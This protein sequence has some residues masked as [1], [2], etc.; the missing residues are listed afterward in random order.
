VLVRTSEFPLN[1][2]EVNVAVPPRMMITLD[3]D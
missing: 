3:L 1:V 2:H